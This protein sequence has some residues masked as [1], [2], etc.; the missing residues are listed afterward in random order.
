MSQVLI[1]LGAPD[2]LFR[3]C[4]DG[5]LRS[6]KD[7]AKQCLWL[8]RH[9]DGPLSNRNLVARDTFQICSQCPVSS[10]PNYDRE[11]RSPH[12]K[13]LTRIMK[14]KRTV[15]KSGGIRWTHGSSTFFFS[16]A[17]KSGSG[18]ASLGNQWQ[19][20]QRLLWRQRPGSG[21]GHGKPIK[22]PRPS[23]VLS[24]LMVFGCFIDLENTDSSIEA[25]VRV[26]P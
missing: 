5:K 10:C 19:V 21:I 6:Y 9:V 13:Y 3:V 23:I 25:R 2:N 22:F 17:R 4:H 8:R 20:L 1:L 14:N 12:F 26:K 18:G 16:W 7:W 24:C 11:I 15:F